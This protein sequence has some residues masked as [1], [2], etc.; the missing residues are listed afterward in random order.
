MKIPLC[1]MGRHFQLNSAG[2]AGEHLHQLGGAH[3]QRREPSDLGQPVYTDRSRVCPL[4]AAEAAPSQ[5]KALLK[6]GAYGKIKIHKESK[7]RQLMHPLEV[8]AALELKFGGALKGQDLGKGAVSE[9]NIQLAADAKFAD[10][11]LKAV[12]RL[13]AAVVST[14][15]N[16]AGTPLRLAVGLFYLVLRAL[17]TVEDDMDLTRFLPFATDG[18]RAKAGGPAAKETAVALVTK[19]RLLST[20]HLLLRGEGRQHQHLQLHGIGEGDEASLL[21]GMEGVLRLFYTLPVLCQTVVADITEEMGVG[22]AS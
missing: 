12:S 2:C 1:R 7:V 11:K 9:V 3:L 17:D 21:A 13:F 5:A 18:D 22:M 19:Q 8:A 20:F 15:P 16:E 14:L 10:K 4:K 6:Q